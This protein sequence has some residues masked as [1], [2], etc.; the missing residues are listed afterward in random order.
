MKQSLEK[1]KKLATSG[2]VRGVTS[3]VGATVIDSRDKTIKLSK[4]IGA[5]EDKLKSMDQIIRLGDSFY[6][7][8]VCWR[9]NDTG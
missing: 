3:A 4:V 7:K 6:T 8:R 2:K 1:L 9:T 5:P